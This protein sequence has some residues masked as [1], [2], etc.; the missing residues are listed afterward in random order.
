M[1]AKGKIKTIARIEHYKIWGKREKKDIQ[2]RIISF[3][4][5]KKNRGKLD[6]SFGENKILQFKAVP[7]GG[8]I[9]YK[10][11]D[12]KPVTTLVI[13]ACGLLEDADAEVQT[14]FYKNLEDRAKNNVA[15]I[16]GD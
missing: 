5:Q 1:L 2:R 16:M 6:F 4:F 11:I 10:L 9:L 12:N 7:V 15:I 13:Y 3:L 14:N 8:R